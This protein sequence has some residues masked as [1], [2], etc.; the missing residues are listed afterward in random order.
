[1]LDTIELQPGEALTDTVFLENAY[2]FDMHV[3]GEYTVLTAMPVLGDVDAVYV[4]KPIKV[5]VTRG[6]R[7]PH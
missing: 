2:G 4:A 1:M 5:T 6:A 7:P 3:P